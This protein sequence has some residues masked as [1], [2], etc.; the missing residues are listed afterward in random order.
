MVT[1]DAVYVDA[2]GTE[3]DPGRVA[4]PTDLKIP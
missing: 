3:R 1:I 2:L 4:L